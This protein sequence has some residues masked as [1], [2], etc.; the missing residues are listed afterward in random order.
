MKYRDSRP[1]IMRTHGGK[2]HHVMV[3]RYYCSRCHHLHTQLPDV[4]LPY[5]HYCSETV[6]DVLD[7]IVD[8]QSPEDADGPSPMTMKEW[9]KWFQINVLRMEGL[10]KNALQGIV[11]SAKEIPESDGSL[12]KY[13]RDHSD[14]WLSTIIRYIYNSGGFLTSLRSR[15]NAPAFR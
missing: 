5:K 12:L 10:A 2:T 6:Q 9:R 8:E 3:R 7:E 15:N 1:R 4:L 11:G 14:R 13:Y